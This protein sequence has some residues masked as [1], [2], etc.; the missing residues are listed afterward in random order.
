MA[1][2][3]SPVGSS[4]AA[5]PVLE[6][7]DGRGSKANGL[8]QAQAD[9]IRQLLAQLPGGKSSSSP[10]TG[11]LP[12]ASKPSPNARSIDAGLDGAIKSLSRPAVQQ[13]PAQIASGTRPRGLGQSLSPAVP[14]TSP[15]SDYP[16]LEPVKAGRPAVRPIPGRDLSDPNAP[17]P[18]APFEQQAANTLKDASEY[19]NLLAPLR[20]KI[21]PGLADFAQ[22][23]ALVA[24]AGSNLLRLTSGNADVKGKVTVEKAAL[25]LFNAVAAFD[26]KGIG[27]IA[28]Y[29]NT[30]EK[31]YNF[32]DGLGKGTLSGANAISGGIG[33]AN[34][35][36]GLIPGVPR[37]AKLVGD[38]LALAAQAGAFGGA[39][40]AGLAAGGAIPV[41]GFGIAAVSFLIDVFSTKTEKFSQEKPLVQ[42]ISTDGRGAIDPATGQPAAD[43]KITAAFSDETKGRN[44]VNYQTRAEHAPIKDVHFSLTPETVAQ[45][46]ANVPYAIVSMNGP[47]TPAGSPVPFMGRGGAP[48]QQPILIDGKLNPVQPPYGTP[49]VPVDSLD[50]A[51]HIDIRVADGTIVHLQR[52]AGGAG[53]GF[54]GTP[55]D[56]QLKWAL[57]AESTREGPA[58]GVP[59]VLNQDQLTPLQQVATGNFKLHLHT[60]FAAI[61]PATRDV[62]LEKDAVISSAEAAKIRTA[63]GADSGAAAGGDARIETLRGQI[64]TLTSVAPPRSDGPGGRTSDPY[65][66]GTVEYRTTEQTKLYTYGDYNF[67]GKG[68]LV[69]QS[70]SDANDK[71]VKV[72]FGSAD[73]TQQKQYS[74]TAESGAE[75][76]QVG[77]RANILLQYVAS[78]PELYDLYKGANGERARENA[79]GDLALVYR[80]VRDTGVLPKLDQLAALAGPPQGKTPQAQ[81]A[82]I[83]SR[84]R[85]IGQLKKELGITVEPTFLD[86]NPAVAAASGHQTLRILDDYIASGNAAGQAVNAKGQTL[87]KWQPSANNWSEKQALDYVAANPDL[88]KA[89]GANADGARAHWN[90][91][92]FEGRPTGGFNVDAFLAGRPDVRAAANAALAKPVVIAVNNM[93][94]SRMAFAGRG[95]IMPGPGGA[96]VTD[97]VSNVTVKLPNDGG[98]ALLNRQGGGRGTPVS[99]TGRPQMGM[100]GLASF[101]SRGAPVPGSVTMTVDELNALPKAGPSED[102]VRVFATKNFITSTAAAPPAPPPPAPAQPLFAKN[103]GRLSA[104]G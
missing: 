68:D 63:F 34:A 7:D 10:A 11:A 1:M 23:A 2:S 36:L 20:G 102:D 77:P 26:P 4:N 58:H 71:S 76:A 14:K 42:G 37:E 92:R 24:N 99:F 72:A 91:H 12:P 33:L 103:A 47:A 55:A 30:A 49:R 69:E 16:V 78:H 17:E 50:K 51:T 61:N 60:N 8:S 38:G 52:M 19:F 5:I 84:G 48:T 22:K 98:F 29:V 18:A 13:T 54:F 64:N 90:A 85:Q 104:N 9:L 100:A 3:I 45:P 74:I 86:R 21:D 88:I 41:I 15:K 83:V 96:L 82:D 40:L 95:A 89:I 46:A 94:I 59:Y 75:A 56:S 44:W 66:V 65:P 93:D 6:P 35:V 31:A 73:G 53:R 27:K 43:G 97:Q 67:D 101:I 25:S 28:P 87:T 79:S 70:L 62:G 32:I 81:F 80:H 57:D 39:G